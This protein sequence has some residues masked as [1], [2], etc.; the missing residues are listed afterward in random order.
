M[1]DKWFLLFMNLSNL[2]QKLNFQQNIGILGSL[3]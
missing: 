2:K 3:G 1:C